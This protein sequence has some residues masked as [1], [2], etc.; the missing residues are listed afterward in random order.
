MNRNT[1]SRFSPGRYL[2][3]GVT[4]VEL[5]VT[6]SITGI[7]MAGLMGLVGESLHIESVT[8]QRIDLV[9]QAR[10]AMQRMTTAVGKSGYLMLPLVDSPYTAWSEAVRDVLAVTLDPTLDRD[11]DG[12][13]DANND[14]D[15][16]DSNQNG[17]RD[18]GEW[19]RIDEDTSGDMTND[20][21]SGIVG[22][23]DD[24]D[25]LVDEAHKN[26]DDEGSVFD[27]DLQ[28]L[29]DADGDLSFSEDLGE[30]MNG[31]GASGISGVDDDGDGAF[32]EGNQKDD[33]EDG[34]SDEDWLDPVVF[35]LNG[36]DLIERTPAINPVD[37]NDFIENVIADHVSAFTVT[38]H[39]VGYQLNP[40]LTID[41]TLTADD[42]ESISLSAT[43]AQ[44]GLL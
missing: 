31:D 9:Q 44:G 26:D 33:D 25:G 7:L 1:A 35:Y 23:D 12:W 16:Q 39:G 38:R 2:Q 20:D 5:M 19:Q 21:E 15:F 17:I 40:L 36:T 22:I 43:V 6:V 42:G 18:D 14:K 24:G 41:L 10:F 37:G 27:E 8:R 3:R 4:L 34:L 30:D 29:Q 11:A 13:A 28:P 32:D